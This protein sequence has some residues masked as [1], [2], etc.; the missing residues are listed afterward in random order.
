MAGWLKAT[1]QPSTDSQELILLNVGLCL[2][3]LIRPGI[4]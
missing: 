3:T 1:V 4:D 2:V